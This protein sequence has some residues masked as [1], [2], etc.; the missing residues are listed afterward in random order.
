MILLASASPRRKA[1]LAL[2]VNDFDVLATNIDETP[3]KNESPSVYVQRM[4]VEKAKSAWST[5]KSDVSLTQKTTVIIASDT[6]VV[7]D[8]MILG[9]PDSFQDAQ[10][11]LTKLSGRSHEVITSICIINCHTNTVL[12]E[13][14]VT[15]VK[16]RSI[17]MQE[18]EQYWLTGE[19]VDKAGSYAAQ[20]IGAIFIE[21][22]KGSFSAVVGLPMFETAQLL[23]QVGITPLQEMSCE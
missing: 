2:L 4:A 11:M 17:S 8:D 22:I 18:I 5:V 1:L 21:K 15:E 14:V 9:K 13:N 23:Q 7:I 19:P 3:L 16:F 10:T 6:S 12:T 20:G